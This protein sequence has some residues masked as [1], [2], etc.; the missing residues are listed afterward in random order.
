MVAEFI[1]RF[2]EGPKSPVVLKAIR[3][4]IIASQKRHRAD[5]RKF[6][7]L[8]A[9]TVWR[10][11]V[12]D[13]GHSRRA[14]VWHDAEANVFWLCAVKS[15]SDYP[16]PQ[17]PNLYE[18]LANLY[19][20]GKLL[21]AQEEIAASRVDQYWDAVLSA[22]GEARVKASNHPNEWHEASVTQ[23]DGQRIV[24]GDA[25]TDYEE[26]HGGVIVA[27][28]IVA[29]AD[30]PAGFKRPPN[31]KAL[32]IERCFED[33]DEEPAEHWADLPTNRPPR[34]NVV[35]FFQTAIVEDP[36]QVEE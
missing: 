24:V 36:D 20:A 8:P 15:I 29:V 33:L 30:D 12:S 23:P 31:W 13:G 9:E 26:C 19:E 1:N 6:A 27:H 21:P 5:P 22:L 14:A 17:E 3:E 28:T 35:P 16:Q 11:R 32:I 18:H 4:R 34:P 10:I 25:Y 2:A 7:E